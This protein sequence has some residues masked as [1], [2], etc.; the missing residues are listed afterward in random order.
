MSAKHLYS[1]Q[2]LKGL[3]GYALAGTN[4]FGRWTHFVTG[5][6]FTSLA[7]DT[8]STVA[9]STSTT[10]G[11]G[12]LL[13]TASNTDNNEVA[14]YGTNKAFLFGAGNTLEMRQVFQFTELTNDAS[15][16][17][18]GFADASG[19]ATLADLI[20]D[21]GA[22]PHASIASACM[23]Y[24]L[25][26]EAFWTAHME[27]NGTTDTADSVVVPGGSDYKD[28]SINVNCEASTS[29]G[30]AIATFNIDGIPLMDTRGRTIQLR[31]PYASAVT[32]KPF[33]YGKTGAALQLQIKSKFF[34]AGTGN[35]AAA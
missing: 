14:V 32:M 25:D 34:Y 4:G 5:D 29:G 33:L 1:E 19:G 17:A 6:E 30:Q 26:G 28:F 8:T 7:A 23:L 27:I 24:K 22:G 13:L 3:Q 9:M 11:G 18:L 20:L 31:V 21:D 10:E 2:I 15:N 12:V 16:I 35:R